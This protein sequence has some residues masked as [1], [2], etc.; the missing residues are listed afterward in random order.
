MNFFEY[1]PAPKDPST[2]RTAKEADPATRLAVI[3]Q[4]EA[5]RMNMPQRGYPG[6]H[7]LGDELPHIFFELPP[8]VHIET[9]AIIRSDG[10][11]KR[12]SVIWSQ[13]NRRLDRVAFTNHDDGVFQYVVLPDELRDERFFE[14]V[15]PASN[16]STGCRTELIEGERRSHILHFIREQRSNI[17]KELDAQ[18]GDV[19]GYLFRIYEQKETAPGVFVRSSPDYH[20]NIVWSKK[21][22]RFDRVAFGKP[23]DHTFQYLW[24]PEELR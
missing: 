5:Q 17:I 10:T 3:R 11:G 9:G 14:F 24:L 7:E 6:L 15:S 18:T 21:H 12:W 16:P 22:K 23:D 8:L 20:Y 1:T 19:A 4:L 2:E 13:R